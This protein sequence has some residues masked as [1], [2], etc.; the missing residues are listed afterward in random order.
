M[1]DA[2]GHFSSGLLSGNINSFG[3]IDGCLSTKNENLQ[4][5]GKHCYLELQVF[6]NESAIY[7]NHLRKLIQ[8]YE[9]IKSKLNDVSYIQHIRFIVFYTL[10]HNVHT[11]SSL[12]FLIHKSPLTYSCAFLPSFTVFVFLL[13][14]RMMILGS[15]VKVSWMTLLTTLAWALTCKL[16]VK[17][18]MLFKMKKMKIHYY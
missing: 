4:I 14:A 9:I 6:V 3:D 17:C 16:T 5:Y 8:S 10:I 1:Y 18:V 15:L 12:Y 13:R 7:L 2:S 11:F